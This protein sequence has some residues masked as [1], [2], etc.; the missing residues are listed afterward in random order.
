[1]IMMMTLIDKITKDETPDQPQ[2]KEGSSWIMIWDD[3]D[4]IIWDGC[5]TVAAIKCRRLDWTTG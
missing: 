3:D 4:E 5:C 2:D 1:M